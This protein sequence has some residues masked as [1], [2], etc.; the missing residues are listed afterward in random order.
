MGLLATYVLFVYLL[1]YNLFLHFVY[2]LYAWKLGDRYV[3]NLFFF[4][5]LES[6]LKSLFL[7]I[8]HCFLLIRYFLLGKLAIPI[9]QWTL[10]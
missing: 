9:N 2:F 6:V 3:Y 8:I 1:V 4:F 7:I 10:L 5:A